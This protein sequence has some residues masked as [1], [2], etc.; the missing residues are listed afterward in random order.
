MSAPACGGAAI[1]CSAPS[2][3]RV[4]RG[5]GAALAGKD[6][7]EADGRRE[8]A[9]REREQRHVVGDRWRVCQLTSSG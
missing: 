9:G 8:N 2:R 7:G 1:L 5:H 4:K 3:V 6:G